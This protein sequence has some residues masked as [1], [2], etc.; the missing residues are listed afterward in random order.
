MRA[1]KAHEDSVFERHPR[2]ML[3]L[4]WLAFL[5]L[6]FLASEIALRQLTGLGRPVLFQAHPAYGYRLKPNQETWRF[7]GAHFKINNLGLRAQRDWDSSREGKILFLGDSV[8]YGGNHVSNEELFS[9]VAAARLA[10]F[11]AGNAG[12]PN[13]GV[14]NV[15]GLVVGAEFLPASV[16]VSTF[17]E[18]DFYRGLDPGLKLPWVRYEPPL[19]A[20]EELA[21]FVWH[22][23]VIDTQQSNR[24][25]RE[26]DPPDVRM[27]RGATKLQAMD[28]YLKD[29]GFPHFVFISPTLEEVLGEAPRDP[30][31]HAA[32]ARLG[33]E[34]VYLLDEPIMR[35]ATP[36][37]RRSWFQDDMHLTPKGHAVWGALIGERLA[38]K[39]LW[40]IPPI[41]AS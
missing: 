13:W 26:A 6:F 36:A 28:A 8:T 37:E 1:M 7:G 38:E 11:E 17:I 4:F 25:V 29:R 5:L 15:H 34:A 23:H 3:A 21:D 33:I 32:L 27:A 31:V 12:I 22:K 35:A 9:E 40:S 24:R 41:P 2:T 16:Y 19:L 18:G 30:K 39:L 10:G 20:L 14:E